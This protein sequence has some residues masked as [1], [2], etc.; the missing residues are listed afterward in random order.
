MIH[1]HILTHIHMHI[2]VCMYIYIYIYIHKQTN[3][4]TNKQTS[5]V[6][7]HNF[8]LQTFNLRVSNP[9]KLMV[10]VFV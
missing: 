1:I 7:F 8:N 9:N 6:G 2:Y 4:Q 10:D 5:T 3:K